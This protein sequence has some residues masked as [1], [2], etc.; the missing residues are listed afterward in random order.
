VASKDG[1]MMYTVPLTSLVTL[2]SANLLQVGKPAKID[3]VHL[4]TF[5][6]ATATPPPDT[7]DR[8]PT[9]A[10][11]AA[12]IGDTTPPT[13]SLRFQ[14]PVAGTAQYVF[15]KII[16][17]SPRGES[18]IDNSNYTLAPVSEIGLQLTHGVTPE[19][20]VKNPVAVQLTGVGGNVKIYRR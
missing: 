9:V 5:P 2:A 19:S 20:P 11:T 17:F 18:V 4:K 12:Q 3:N 10:S 1:T 7:F 8:R 6:N 15:T 14:Y 16:Q 13:P